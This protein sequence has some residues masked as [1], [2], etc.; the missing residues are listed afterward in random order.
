MKVINYCV[1]MNFRPLYS[2]N[3]RTDMLMPVASHMIESTP[4]KR[5]TK[6]PKHSAQVLQQLGID[7]AQAQ[8]AK[9][10][11]IVL[12]DGRS[13]RAGEGTSFGGWVLNSKHSTTTLLETQ[14]CC[15][16]MVALCLLIDCW[17]TWDFQI[18]SSGTALFNFLYAMS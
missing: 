4:N 7:C 5:R 2:S 11:R 10:F 1:W 12:R 18:L 13:G 6:A 14:K 16:A 8:V 3:V 9:A 15:K 17:R